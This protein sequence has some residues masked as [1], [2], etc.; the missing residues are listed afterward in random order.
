MRRCENTADKHGH[1]RPDASLG[2]ACIGR[3]TRP[4]RRAFSL[5]E[6]LVVI[7][8]IAILIAI[9]L[10]TL[11]AARESGRQAACLSNLR[12]IHIAFQTYAD[13]YKGLSPGLGKPYTTMP[14]WAIAV[15]TAFGAAGDTSTEQ[16]ATR[17]VLV[18]PSASAWYGTPLT[19]TYAA[20]ATGHSGMP[21]DPDDYDNP[22]AGRSVHA[23][24]DL[25][26]FPG[27]S[28]AAIDSAIVQ[29]SE[30]PP[31]TQTS[32]VL[33]FRRSEHDARIGR[34]HATKG[35]KPG[36]FDAVFY[37][38]SARMVADVSAEFQERLP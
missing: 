7:A 19:R 10:P 29:Q 36:K 25:I 4:V 9:L 15:Q 13:T 6:L 2:P 34:V 11:A 1:R 26:P 21:G 22:P 37:D 23:R 14:N 3:Y 32:G 18:C 38:G 28:P 20:N 8:V 5:I 16:Y 31:P 17:L 35:G 27:R 24:I 12:Q 33:D 30:G